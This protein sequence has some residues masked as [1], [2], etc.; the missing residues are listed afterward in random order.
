MTFLPFPSFSCHKSFAEKRWLVRESKDIKV[1]SAQKYI[2][3]LPRTLVSVRQ[4]DAAL[5][6]GRSTL[7]NW[8]ALKLCRFS[9]TFRL[10]LRFWAGEEEV[11]MG[12]G[13]DRERERQG[14][15][16]A[17]R[18]QM[19]VWIGLCTEEVTW[20]NMWST[21]SF[22]MLSYGKDFHS[23]AAKYP[24]ALP[25]ILFKLGPISPR[26]WKRQ[27]GLRHSPCSGV[28]H[29]RREM[30]DKRREKR[31]AGQ[32]CWEDGHLTQAWTF[33][34]ASQ[35][36][37]D[38]WEAEFWKVGWSYLDKEEVTS[39]PGR[40]IRLWK[41]QG[42]ATLGGSAC[43]WKKGMGGKERP[44]PG[45]ELDH[46]GPCMPGQE[47]SFILNAIRDIWRLFHRI[48]ILSHWDRTA[49]ISRMLP[50]AYLWVLGSDV[51]PE[52]HT[53]V[54]FLL[55]LES[56]DWHPWPRGW[57][58]FHGVGPL[59]GASLGGARNELHSHDVRGVGHGDRVG[60]NSCYHC[61]LVP[62]WEATR[63]SPG[64]WSRSPCT[65]GEIQPFIEPKLFPETVGLWKDLTLYS[66]VDLDLAPG[67]VT[68][69]E[70]LSKLITF[71][72]PQFFIYKMDVIMP[73]SQ[74]Y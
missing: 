2:K 49:G 7:R 64:R 40:R 29:T 53:T 38:G 13:I 41:S 10:K 24:Q 34:R 27:H 8:K 19:C 16:K 68:S 62:S 59:G 71:S 51:W 33:R 73:L 44:M 26:C 65:S 28:T 48:V 39:T 23:D 17:A 9:C 4:R 60:H 14:R 31:N 70:T 5:A 57:A 20:A 22:C 18:S 66:Q 12:S 63:H 67:P 61:P 11:E 74:R 25:D 30:A 47:S 15:K 3:G 58:H 50:T 6:R 69:C 54:G 52:T 1:V 72:E 55:R 21:L 37:C 45:R 46:E 43:G 32:L 35:R 36:R 56:R 42:Y